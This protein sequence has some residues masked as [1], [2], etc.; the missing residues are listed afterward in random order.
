M[1]PV[2]GIDTMPLANITP[3][4][5]PVSF[6]HFPRYMFKVLADELSFL[7]HEVEYSNGWSL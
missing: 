5:I 7:S 2:K 6:K 4:D 1:F 3:D